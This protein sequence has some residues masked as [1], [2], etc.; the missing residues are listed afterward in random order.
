[1]VVL[2]AGS[3]VQARHDWDDHHHHDHY[4][5]WD[6]HRRS[7]LSLSF[8]FYDPPPVYY[9]RPVVVERPVIVE[10]PPVIVAD[11]GV[12]T[13]VQIALNRRGFYY[14]RIDGLAGPQTRGAIASYQESR[15]LYP[16]GR[17]D[18]ALLRSLGLN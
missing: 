8:G 3:V 7:G 1:M 10:Q 17:I 16:S 12:V 9:S 13:D 18:Y 5:R 11:R 15:G 6:H 2:G 14:G 4:D